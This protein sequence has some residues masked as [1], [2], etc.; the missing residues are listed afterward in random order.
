MSIDNNNV[1]IENHINCAELLSS[2]FRM[3]FGFI[4]K[5]VA[6]TMFPAS[7]RLRA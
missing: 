7:L 1:D 5:L 3:C 6:N 2:F 4:F